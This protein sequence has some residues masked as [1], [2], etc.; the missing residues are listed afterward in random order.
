MIAVKRL[1][2]DTADGNINSHLTLMNSW[3]KDKYIFKYSFKGL[4]RN[5]DSL[6]F[7]DVNQ[8]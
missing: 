5:V 6:N 1:C 3:R 8:T 2:F 4:M 7:S